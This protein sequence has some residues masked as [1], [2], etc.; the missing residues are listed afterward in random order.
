M[1][2]ELQ[3]Q[4]KQV[5]TQAKTGQA[6]GQSFLQALCN[7]EGIEYYAKGSPRPQPF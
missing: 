2:A 4:L 3:E 6:Y 7:A 1:T 5:C